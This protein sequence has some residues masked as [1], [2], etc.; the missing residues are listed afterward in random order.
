MSTLYS[1]LRLFC[2]DRARE[3]DPRTA[4]HSRRT[5]L[6]G[7]VRCNPPHPPPFQTAH[8]FPPPP[9]RWEA[10]RTSAERPRLGKRG[11][12]MPTKA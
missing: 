10:V 2:Q 1:R 12:K 6:L 4:A 11:R 9:L 3:V 5:A 8:H 7:T